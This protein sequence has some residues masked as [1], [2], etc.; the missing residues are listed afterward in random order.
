MLSYAWGSF[1]IIYS[2]NAQSNGQNLK[3]YEGIYGIFILAVTDY[4]GLLRK[5]IHINNNDYNNR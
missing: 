5:A 3:M 2:H 4:K 1:I